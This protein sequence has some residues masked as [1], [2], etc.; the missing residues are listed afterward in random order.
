MVAAD[1]MATRHSNCSTGLIPLGRAAEEGHYQ[2]AC[3]AVDNIAEANILPDM[4]DHSSDVRKSDGG[5]LKRVAIDKHV[6]ATTLV[7]YL[8]RSVKAEKLHT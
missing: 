3:E 8:K 5:E 1:S 2:C 4:H 6:Q 7:F